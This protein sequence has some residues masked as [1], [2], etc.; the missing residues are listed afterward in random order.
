[1]ESIESIRD[2]ANQSIECDVCKKLF[3]NKYILVQHKKKSK[4]CLSLQGT[5]SQIE[6]DYCLKKLST[7]IVV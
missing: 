7:K 3:K 1:M 6:C 4:F 2:E 5:S